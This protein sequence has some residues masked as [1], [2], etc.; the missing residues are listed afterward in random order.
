[1]NFDGAILNLKNNA[2]KS[3]GLGENLQTDMYVLSLPEKFLN[4]SAVSFLTYDYEINVNENGKRGVYVI[5][6]KD[7]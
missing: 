3:L 7:N 4:K 2:T 6:R 5:R 1:M